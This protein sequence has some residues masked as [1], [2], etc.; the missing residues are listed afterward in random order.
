MSRTGVR[1]NA[2]L[3]DDEI[4]LVETGKVINVLYYFLKQEVYC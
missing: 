2:A 3:E 1:E 4:N